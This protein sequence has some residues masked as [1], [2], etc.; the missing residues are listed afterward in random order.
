M[1]RTFDLFQVYAC[2]AGQVPKESIVDTTGAGD[3]YIASLMYGL[4]HGQSIEH[5]LRLGSVVSAC[6]CTRL[7]A[8]PG[9]PRQEDMAGGWL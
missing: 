5:M 4:V 1:L 8:R 3:A 2:S 6:K 7:G 9:L